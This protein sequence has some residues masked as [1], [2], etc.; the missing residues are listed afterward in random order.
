M[1]RDT[2]AVRMAPAVRLWRTATAVWMA[3]VLVGSLLPAAAGAPSGILWHILG[4]G[5]L[6]ALWSRWQTPGRAALLAWGYGALI[7]GVQWVVPYRT[8]E[9][10]DL[11]VNAAGVAAGLILVGAWV[12]LAGGRR[13]G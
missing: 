4:Y 3:L 7:E 9:I 11:A 10:A 6:A 12:R 5:V 2:A 1:T 13:P 8:A